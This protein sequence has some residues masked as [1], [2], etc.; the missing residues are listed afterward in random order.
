MR[1]EPTV[2]FC[3]ETAAVTRWI[4][5]TGHLAIVGRKIG[6]QMLWRAVQARVTHGGHGGHDP[7]VSRGWGRLVKHWLLCSCPSRADPGP[8]LDVVDIHDNHW[9]VVGPSHCTWAAVVN[10]F[11]NIIEI[12]NIVAQ[13]TDGTY[14]EHAL[15]VPL[16]CHYW[17]GST[18]IFDNMLH[19][20]A[21][22]RH[23][24]TTNWV[25]INH[26]RSL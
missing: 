9:G 5:V 11:G 13:Y 4:T 20:R 17:R 3:R 6:P 24:H 22:T 25:C 1:W 14:A 7:R 2:T 21:K 23:I 18:Y 10:W 26:R 12:S 15:W 19:Q 8:R 16:P